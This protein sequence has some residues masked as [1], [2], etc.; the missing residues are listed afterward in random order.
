M[1]PSTRKAKRE[2]I[3]NEVAL[4]RSAKTSM[5]NKGEK[6]EGVITQNI[7]GWGCRALG[8]G[9]DLH[10]LK[11]ESKE[12]GHKSSCIRKIGFPNGE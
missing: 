2:N 8:P 12:E 3:G 9:L 7:Q 4:V 1:N 5:H 10:S 6:N 11:K